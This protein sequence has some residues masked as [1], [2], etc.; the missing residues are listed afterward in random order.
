MENEKFRK[1][2][3]E[4]KEKTV[5]DYC[6]DIINARSYDLSKLIEHKVIKAEYDENNNVTWYIAGSE[7]AYT[8]YI[9]LRKGLVPYVL[10]LDNGKYFSED[11]FLRCWRISF[12]KK[13]LLSFC[14]Q[15]QVCK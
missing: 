5:K 4:K 2:F 9:Q 10:H 1:L 14:L 13:S 3:E 6:N 15:G 12:Q 7:Q 11:E 8:S